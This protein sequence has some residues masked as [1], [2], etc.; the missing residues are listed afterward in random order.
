MAK[1]TPE[2]PD[3]LYFKI[4]EVS[5]ITGIKPYVLRY[6]ETEFPL[7][8]KKSRTGQRLYKR[9]DIE[10]VLE[11]SRLLYQEGFTI[12]GARRY[13]SSGGS[14]GKSE[15]DGESPAKEAQAP[16]KSVDTEALLK[17]KEHVLLLRGKLQTLRDIP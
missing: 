10:L 3:K 17:I 14:D 2:I 8:P 12:A 15:G 11:I 13:L 5:E 7:S 16:Q 4:G 6:W 1:D 9:E